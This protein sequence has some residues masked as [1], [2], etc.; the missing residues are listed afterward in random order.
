MQVQ[1]TI[2]LDQATKEENMAKTDIL[3]NTG[4]ETTMAVA[5][6]VMAT[7]NTGQETT[8]AVA[9]VVMATENTGQETTMAVAVVVMTKRT[10]TNQG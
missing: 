7:E 6:V 1:E 8:M 9:V 10:D 5:V 3:R 4:Q 2:A